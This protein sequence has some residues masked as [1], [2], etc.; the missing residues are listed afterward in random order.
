[1]S[2]P[3]D[4]KLTINK[5]MSQPYLIQRLQKPSQWEIKGKKMDYP[6]SF[7]GGLKN[8]GL[9]DNA[10]DLIR[11]IFSFDYMGSAEFEY[12]A[13][14]QALSF[15][16][17]QAS[18]NNL[19]NGEI[20]VNKNEIVYYLSPREY[21]KEVI[22][23][24]KLLRQDSLRLKEHCG[25]NHYFEGFLGHPPRKDICGWLELDNGYMFFTDKHMYEQT[26]KLFGV[27]IK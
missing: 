15:L 5:K 4:N 25:L 20:E 19:I 23:C 21:E 14:P 27:L 12:G 3:G 6:F 13:V 16:A 11:E 22:D 1:M 17:S 10:M 8:G 26:S 24:I 18:K 7:G 2:F 9:S